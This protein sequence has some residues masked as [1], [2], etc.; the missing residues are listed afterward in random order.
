VELGLVNFEDI[1]GT[2]INGSES[3][4]WVK[5]LKEDLTVADFRYMMERKLMAAETIT[6]EDTGTKTTNWLVTAEADLTLVD[7]RFLTRVYLREEDL[8]VQDF[9]FF[10]LIKLREDALTIFDEFV[11]TVITGGGSITTK[12]IG[13]NILMTDGA[14]EWVYRRRDLSELLTILDN[15][16]FWARRVSTLT[17]SI[18][19]N[20]SFLSVLWKRRQV[21]DDLTIVDSIVDG[22][23]HIKYVTDSLAVNDARSFTFVA[24]R[25]N[26]LVMFDEFIKNVVTG[27]GITIKVVGENLVMTDGAADWV[28]RR[29]EIIDAL[30]IPDQLV[31][32]RALVR[33][34]LDSVTIAEGTVNYRIDVR[35]ITEFL[36]LSDELQ[37]T[38]IP[39]VTFTVRIIIGSERIKL[40]VLGTDTPNMLGFSV[41]IVLGDDVPIRL[42]YQPTIVIGIGA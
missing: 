15:S 3:T 26:T 13:E 10:K 20:D 25:E 41:P 18:A 4:N 32:W 8:T 39:G 23:R 29:R 27:G 42:G 24:L 35:S 19:L 7:Q 30:V 34:A 37:K 38:F 36:T 2:D 1:N 40:N 16:Q 5:A 31:F 17:E 28:F 9:R 33:Q 12:V 11:K 14:V 22:I 6:I 21:E